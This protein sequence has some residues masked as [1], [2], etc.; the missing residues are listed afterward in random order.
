M[1]LSTSVTD[2]ADK[3]RNQNAVIHSL[4]LQLAVEVQEKAQGQMYVALKQVH[5][6][7]LA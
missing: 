2:I 6:C 3:L 5:D 7:I 1:P 4:Y